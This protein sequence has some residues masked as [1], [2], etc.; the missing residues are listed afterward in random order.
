MAIPLFDGAREGSSTTS[1][2]MLLGHLSF[3]NLLKA[4]LFSYFEFGFTT[5]ASKGVTNGTPMVIIVVCGLKKCRLRAAL[6]NLPYNP[7]QLLLGAY[8]VS[9]S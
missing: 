8:I 6:L 7:P 1:K 3:S 4:R 9:S 5:S 2:L